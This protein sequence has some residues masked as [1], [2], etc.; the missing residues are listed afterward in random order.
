MIAFSACLG[1]GLFLQTGHIIY[2]AGPGM[3]LVCYLLAGSVMWSMMASLG[4]MTALFPIQG[5]IFE[6]KSRGLVVQRELTHCHVVSCRFLD[7]AVGFAAAWMVWFAWCVIIGSELLAVAQL[8]KFNFDP[9]YLTAVGYPDAELRWPV[10]QNYS[11]ALFVFIFLVAIG[12]PNL[13]PV[14]WYGNLEYIFGCIKMVFLVGLVLFNMILNAMKLIPNEA[15]SRFWTYDEPYGFIAS[16]FTLQAAS[17]EPSSDD[18]V[19]TGPLGQLAG[20]WS[21]ITIIM[22][23]LIGFDTTAITAA[24]NKDLQRNESVKMAARKISLRII[25]LYGMFTHAQRAPGS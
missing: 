14:L 13:L 19:I 4:E 5:P 9:A 7:E 10:G 22:F 12:L 1:I 6:C 23:S 25:L 16:N 8:F 17:P 24:E 15:N 21:A 2:L 18:V 20:V 11:Q 3:A